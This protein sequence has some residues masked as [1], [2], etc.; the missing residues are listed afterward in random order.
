MIMKRKF[1][2]CW[3]TIPAISTKQRI[4]LQHRTQ[5]DHEMWGWKSRSWFGTGT[6]KVWGCQWENKL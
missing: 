6:R 4:T 2:Q 1:K 5:K 3:S